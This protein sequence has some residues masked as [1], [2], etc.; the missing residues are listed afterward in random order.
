MQRR[1]SGVTF[2]AVVLGVIDLFLLFSGLVNVILAFLFA[3]NPGFLPTAPN[4]PAPPAH[5]MVAFMGFAAL[6]TLICATWGIS[7]FFGLLRMKNWARISIMIIGGCLTAL[8]LIQ[9]FGCIIAQVSMKNLIVPPN[10]GS[11]NLLATNPD[12]LQGAFLFID[13]FCLAVAAV[14]IWWLVYFAR[15]KTRDA[16]ELVPVEAKLSSTAQLNPGTPITDFSLAQPIAQPMEVAQ[17]ATV[18]PVVEVVPAERARPI[19]MTIVAVLLFLS[20]LS[21]L[22]CCLLPFPLFFFGIEMSGWSAHIVLLSMAA[23]YVLAGYG[24]LQRMHFGWV[25]AVGIQILA[26]LNVLTMLSPPV[27]ERWIAY[28]RSM[29]ATMMPASPST[30]MLPTQMLQQNMMREMMIPSLVLGAV[31]V[32]FLLVLLWRARWAYK[33]SR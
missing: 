14:G 21:M 16:F 30:A 23:L 17:P 2:S 6:T 20:A 25:L 8:A 12:A 15:R 10:A 28:T 24:L 1:P 29:A 3:R 13:T 32:L 22:F 7:T 33:S 31:F 9:L 19:S 27:R 26:L 18:I 11:A 4:Q 5:L